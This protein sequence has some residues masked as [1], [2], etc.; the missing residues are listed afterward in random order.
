MD[1]EDSLEEPFRELKSPYSGKKG[2]EAQERWIAAYE[3]SKRQMSQEAELQCQGGLGFFF[4]WRE[5]KSLY[6]L[7]DGAL[8]PCHQASLARQDLLGNRAGWLLAWGEL[9]QEH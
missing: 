7:C 2:I 6:F 1:N 5:L 3:C 8:T 4:S 9:A